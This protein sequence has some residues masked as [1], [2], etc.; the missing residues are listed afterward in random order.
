LRR[1]AADPLRGL[2]A[3][4]PALH[5]RRPS[6]LAGRARARAGARRRA[7]DPR[8]PPAAH[9][10]EP[11]MSLLK[12][13]A[14]LP[15]CYDE[16]I[17]ADGTARPR[18]R[19]CPDMLAALSVED[20]ARNQALAELALLNQGVTFSV[21]KDARGTEKIFPF[22]LIPRIISSA[23]W[24]RLERGLEQRLRALNLFLDDIY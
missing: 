1:A 2:R 17:R 20:L 21:Y 9:R 14:A 15:G 22:C 12:G 7:L 10:S 3:P 24:A 18:L 8:P 13:Y 11:A 19:P 16:L 23:D 5:R 6:A 4:G